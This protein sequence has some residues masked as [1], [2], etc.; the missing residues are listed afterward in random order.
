MFKNIVYF[1]TACSNG[2]GGGV[3]IVVP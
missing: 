3:K 1:G 2:T